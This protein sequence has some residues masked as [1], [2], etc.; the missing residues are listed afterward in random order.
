MAIR[1]NRRVDHRAGCCARGSST[2]HS[3]R[4]ERDSEARRGLHWRMRMSE[5]EQ[6]GAELGESSFGVVSA[7]EL[8]NAKVDMSVVARLVHQ[9]SWT[10]LWRG[11]YLCAGS[12]VGPLVRAHAATKH[13]RQGLPRARPQPEVVMSGLA[14]AQ[15]LGLRWVPVH[16]RVQVLVGPQVH[17]K[18]N[19]QVLVRR[20]A[21]VASIDTWRWGGLAVADAARL[22]VD[23]TRECLSLRDVR[24]LVLGAIADGHADAAS[25]LELLD[26]GAV[27]GTAWA[28]RAVGDAVRGAASPPE[29]ELVDGLLGCGHPFYVNPEVRVS[30]AFVGY[31]DVYLVG[32]GVGAEVDSKER[33]GQEDT[34]DD[35]LARHDRAD[36]G[37]LSLVHVTPTRYRADPAAFRARLLGKVVE[38]RSRGLGEPAGIEVIPRGPLLT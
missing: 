10:W 30:G 12:P 3:R 32:T 11:M 23:G 7:S 37:G 33:H 35:T 29:A 15:A 1:D 31:L 4:F 2:V 20:T 26:A 17:R 36:T 13:A 38:R 16:E 14:G 28:R 24:G 5:V 6:L 22:V 8:R 25:L 34:L 18:S 21:D 27:G 9:Q 19:D